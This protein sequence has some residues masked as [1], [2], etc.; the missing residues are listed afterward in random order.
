MGKINK[1]M[2]EEFETLDQAME[3]LKMKKPHEY[4]LDIPGIFSPT[5]MK[6]Q[7]TKKPTNLTLGDPT[8]HSNS[9]NYVSVIKSGQYGDGD[10]DSLLDEGL[11]AQISEEQIRNFA[12]MLMRDRLN[13]GNSLNRA[14]SFNTAMGMAFSVKDNAGKDGGA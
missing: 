2:D 11:H 12:I 3:Y 10:V 9:L 1:A 13:I 14:D 5:A 8:T 7:K 4:G 6:T